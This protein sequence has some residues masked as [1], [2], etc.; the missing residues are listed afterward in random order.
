[1]RKR[2]YV[3]ERITNISHLE[4]ILEKERICI[5]VLKAELKKDAP[6]T[7]ILNSAIEQLEATNQKATSFEF[8]LER[9]KTC[10]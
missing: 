1:M 5:T 7:E 6:S 10:N 8:C 9:R 3:S 4:K 2:Y